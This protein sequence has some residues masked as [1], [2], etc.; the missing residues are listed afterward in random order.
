ME[1]SPVEL[2]GIGIEIRSLKGTKHMDLFE[3][4]EA[5]RRQKW[6]LI[7]G[8]LLI[9][10][11]I[12]YLGFDYKNGID[13]RAKPRYE[14][15]IQIAV[16]P[17]DFDSLASTFPNARTMAGTASLYAALLASPETAVEI[18]EGSGVE[19]LNTLAVTTTGRDGFIDVKA[20]AR[21]ATGATSAALYSFTWLEQRITAPPS[22]VRLDQQEV[23]PT[24]PPV[25]DKNG[26][27]MGTIRLQASPAFAE[28]AI[29]LWV[30]LTTSDSVVTVSLADAGER[31]SEF[32]ALLEPDSEMVVSLEDV[33]GNELDAVTVDIPP[34]PEPGT[35]QY[36]LVVR[37]DR[38]ILLYPPPS[39][40]VV[41][42]EEV[43]AVVVSD[44]KLLVRHLGV[45]WQETLPAS[46]VE[47]DSAASDAVGLLLLTE[48]PIA[49]VTGARRGPVL[50]LAA[51]VGGFFALVVFVIG[52]DTWIR[53][54]RRSEAE[55][56]ADA[57]LVDDNVQEPVE[58]KVGE[59]R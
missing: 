1:R 18:S 46:T 47:D 45:S 11:L 10:G 17:A 55:R 51:L 44:P 41:D 13:F 5:L 22:I 43:V 3:F 8:G 38:G 48:T 23:E 34:L 12:A 19:L 57:W 28:T 30:G 36:A 40:E 9:V 54:K 50:I 15:S 42:G 29:G 20:T 59:R 26:P 52:T 16:V 35:A 53:A 25:P 33:F 37:L 56:L 32:T 58:D 39:T 21:D 6:I 24:P 49:T 14:S 4:T 27:F 7:I 2:N 31:I